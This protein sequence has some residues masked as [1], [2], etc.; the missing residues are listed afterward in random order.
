MLTSELS[1]LEKPVRV[2]ITQTGAKKDIELT[3]I[4]TTTYKVSESNQVKK[5]NSFEVIPSKQEE[6]KA[7]SS[8][9]QTQEIVTEKNDSL[10]STVSQSDKVSEKKSKKEKR[11]ASVAK[12]APEDPKRVAMR[13]TLKLANNKFKNE[14]QKTKI[15][16]RLTKIN[17]ELSNED[18]EWIANKISKRQENVKKAEKNWTDIAIRVTKRLMTKGSDLTEEKRTKFEQRLAK[19]NEQLTEDQKS[20]VNT[21]IENFKTKLA[22]KAEKPQ[23]PLTHRFIQLWRRIFNNKANEKQK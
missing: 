3:E 15:E 20:D 21:A 1:S 4:A 10:V 5:E 18:Q 9:N 22:K 11:D 14:E 16:E 8:K 17:Q 19:A 12:K 2:F 13:L 6:V 7:S 23:K